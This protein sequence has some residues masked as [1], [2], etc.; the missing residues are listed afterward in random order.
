MQNEMRRDGE[1]GTRRGGVRQERQRLGCGG[2]A[3]SSQRSP[4]AWG[5]HRP[6]PAAARAGRRDGRGPPARRGLHPRGGGGPAGF[7]VASVG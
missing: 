2:A 3:W 6:G 7:E 4:M 5:R 1:G